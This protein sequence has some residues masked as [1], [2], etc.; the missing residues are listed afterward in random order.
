MSLA[1][2]ITRKGN[3]IEE[4]EIDVIISEGATSSSTITKNPV[5]NGADVNDHIIIEPMTF[6]MSGIV[7]D[8]SSSFLQTANQVAAI[9]SGT[10]RSKA[11]WEDLLELQ[12][13]RE[14]F[15]LVQGLKTYENVVIQ[16][17]SETQDKD[18]SNALSFTATLTEIILVG[19]GAPPT[20]EF[21]SDAT[22]DQMTPAT[23]S[24]LKQVV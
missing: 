17:L 24:G 12:T 4:I 22:S 9:G 2:L 14:P 23:D 21:G 7:S 3:F 19:T 11:T 13:R 10:T 5:E 16:S 15:T 1:K 6:Q 8:A 20:T 18:T